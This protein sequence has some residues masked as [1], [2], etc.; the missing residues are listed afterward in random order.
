VTVFYELQ[1]EGA[2]ETLAAFA[3]TLE[4]AGVTSKLLE[5]TR[6]PNLFLL[7]GSL[8]GD[9]ETVAATVAALPDAPAEAKIWQFRRV[10]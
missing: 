1:G 4:A 9:A 5:S 10:R 3:L 6:Q 8:R 2:R 7:R